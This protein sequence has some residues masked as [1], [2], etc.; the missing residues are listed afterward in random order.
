MVKFQER[1]SQKTE[2]GRERE[3]SGRDPPPREAAGSAG[4]MQQKRESR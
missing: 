4:R 1:K 2:R 3:Q